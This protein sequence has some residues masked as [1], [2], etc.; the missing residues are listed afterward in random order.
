MQFFAEKR[1]RIFAAIGCSVLLLS[2]IYLAVNVIRWRSFTPPEITYT[3][4]TSE[5]SVYHDGAFSVEENLLDS[6]TETVFMHISD[7]SLPKGSYSAI[8]TYEAEEDQSASVFGTNSDLYFLNDISVSSP[9]ILSRNKNSADCKFE[10]TEDTRYFSMT[11]NYSGHGTF[12]VRDV[13]LRKTAVMWKRYASIIVMLAVGMA[14]AGLIAAMP[15]QRR[16][17]ILTV[18]ALGAAASIPLA[19]SGLASNSV[20]LEYHLLRIEGLAQTMAD[21][22][23]P[24]RIAGI[25]MDGYGY[26]DAVYYCD[27]L[28]FFPAL[29]RNLGFDITASYKAY[30][31]LLNFLTAGIAFFAFGKMFSSRK[32]GC[33]LAAAYTWSPFRSALFCISMLGGFTAMTFLPLIAYAV[34]RI[35]TS[36]PEK[37]IHFRDAVLLA[38]GMSGVAASHTVTLI[39]TA[40][41]LAVFCVLSIKRTLRK[42]VILTLLCAAGLTVVLCGFYLVPFLDYYMNV[43]TLIQKIGN[44]PGS[45]MIQGEGVAVGQ[46]FS[47]FASM[48]STSFSLNN[49]GT[50]GLLLAALPIGI[51]INTNRKNKQLRCL[52]ILTALSIWMSTDIFPWNFLEAHTWL[53]G[54]LA[55]IQFPYRFN[56]LSTVLLCVTLGFILR[57][58]EE[59]GVDIYKKAS[60]VSAAL[61]LS[62]LVFFVSDFCGSSDF[63][64]SYETESLNTF[65]T[66]LLYLPEDAS[67]YDADY[68]SDILSSG[69]DEV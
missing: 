47:F 50:P 19:F 60:I 46:L 31:V 15:S 65:K 49:I 29:L 53:F 12:S 26:P 27:I 42:D 13:T 24:Q 37:R 14:A 38:V 6:G 11:I 20:D 17:D 18:L 35:Y 1:N 48:S 28:L 68:T 23:L 3:N 66:G 33:I 54:K 59:R 5:W 36:S 22:Q 7:V 8:I 41:L 34:W 69:T 55:Q 25:W 62:H 9:I 10:L 16:R 30:C 43:N 56:A 58:T 51:Y 32:I 67:I 44:T 45:R 61:I 64:Y 2:V 21:G 39:M 63:R 4:W 40:F 52:L 57:Y